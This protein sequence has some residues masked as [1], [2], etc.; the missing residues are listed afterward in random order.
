MLEIKKN[1][2]SLKHTFHPLY[3]KILHILCVAYHKLNGV[4]HCFIMKVKEALNRNFHVYAL[5]VTVIACV[6]SFL[7]YTMLSLV[8]SL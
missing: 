1:P 4:H 2:T 7:A 6:I 3:M 5:Y 8:I